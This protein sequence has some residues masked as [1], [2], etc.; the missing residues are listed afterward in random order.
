MYND[1]IQPKFVRLRDA[2]SFFAMDRNRFCAEIRPRLTQIRIG[3][4]GIAF[5][6]NEMNEVAAAYKAEHTFK[7]RSKGDI[8][9]Q[10]KN[11]RALSAEKRY[12]TSTSPCSGSAFAKAVEQLGLAKR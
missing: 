10:H 9:W 11:H 7:P 6:I 2:P 3:I 12:G 1:R 5:C 4:Q 8:K